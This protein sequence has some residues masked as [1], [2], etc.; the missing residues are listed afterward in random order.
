MRIVIEGGRVID[1][2]HQTDA[3]TDLFIADGRIAGSG[4]PPDPEPCR[5]SSGGAG[6]AIDFHAHGDLDHLRG[7]PFAHAQ[8]PRRMGV[9]GNTV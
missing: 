3:V 6:V 8:S 5:A 9:A 1:P 4:Q 7:C 2:A